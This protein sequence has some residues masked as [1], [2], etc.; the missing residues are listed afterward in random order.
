MLCDGN[1][2][3]WDEVVTVE[4]EPWL[5]VI[6]T[7]VVVVKNPTTASAMHQVPQLALLARPE[8]FYAAAFPRAYATHRQGG[9]R[10][11]RGAQQ[12]H[13]RLLPSGNSWSRASSSRMRFIDMPG[14]LYAFAYSS[15]VSLS[16]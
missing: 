3:A 5:I 9:C 12:T 11:C 4:S 10:P 8:A 15:I 6:A 16:F 14:L 13:S 1:V 2:F 7:L